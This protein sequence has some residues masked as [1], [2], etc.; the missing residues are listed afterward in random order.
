MNRKIIALGIL[1]LAGLV[2]AGASGAFASVT[3]AANEAIN[4]QSSV[5]E[6]SDIME[7]TDL[8]GSGADD[9]NKSDQE[10]V[11][12]GN[13]SDESAQLQ[14]DVKVTIEDAK[15]TALLAVPG[16]IVKAEQKNE[17]ENVVY[18]IEI[19][20]GKTISA[21]KIDAVTGKVLEKETED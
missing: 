14:K 10:T 20:N 18:N 1:L 7:H 19:S 17:K 9:G 21:V 11:D 2:I 4:T 15:K 5:K 8:E 13:G 6:N 16:T 3:H 12:D